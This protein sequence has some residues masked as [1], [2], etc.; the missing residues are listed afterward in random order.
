MRKYYY[1]LTIIMM[2]TLSSCD[3]NE[4]KDQSSGENPLLETFNTPYGVPPFD[5]IETGDY[6]PA[7]TTAMEEHN[8]EI[9]HI[10]NQTE[11]ATFD[12]TLAR[13][14][15]SGELLRRVSSVFSGQ[16]SANT[17]VEI[18]KIAEE[19]SPL[20]SEHADNISL[21]PKLFARVKA[22]Y[23]NREQDPLT[24]EQA[25]LL[26][27][28]YMDFIRSGAN[29]DA[30]KQAELRE[31]NKKLSMMALKFEQHVLDENNAFQLVID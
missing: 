12:N 27:N 30:E 7:F 24:S 4:K 16:M 5:S 17:N 1:L 22:V 13:L 20:L 31:I 15:Y 26:E 10:I 11:S 2:M 6:L 21:N 28:I 19:I 23:D 29:L 14:A 25:Y 8:D 3:Q 18:Q 9:D